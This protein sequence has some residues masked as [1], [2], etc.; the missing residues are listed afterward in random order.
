[1]EVEGRRGHGKL[2]IGEER[3]TENDGLR[4]ERGPGMMLMEAQ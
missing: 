3:S 4:R 1:M 2:A